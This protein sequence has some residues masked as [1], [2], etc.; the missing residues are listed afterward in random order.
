V[1][2]GRGGQRA[3]CPLR[4]VLLDVLGTLLELEPPGPALVTW[5]WRNHGLRL[6]GRVA[7]RAFA[8]E[9]SYYRAHHC[10]GRDAGALARLRRACAAELRAG[11]RGS[12]AQP[13]GLEEVQ[14]A[15]LA[16]IRFRPYPD[17]PDTLSALRAR[18]LRLIA[19]S[20]W[21]ASLHEVLERV[22]LRS[23]LDGAVSSAQVGASKPAPGIFEA[24]LALAGAAPR[25]AVHVGDSLQHDVRGARA[26]GVA[27][28]L[29]RRGAHA[30]AG[31]PSDTSDSVPVIASLAELPALLAAGLSW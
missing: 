6:D 13:L 5:M 30:P 10:E 9:M 17:A 15:M 11:L 29:L 16:S 25:E 28:V 27:A 8:R 26:A 24:A 3:R 2:P 4:A 1:R 14:T 23:A 22:S 20:N 18:G 12:A 31:T 21:D 7:E 19:V